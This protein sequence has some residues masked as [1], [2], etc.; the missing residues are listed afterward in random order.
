MGGEKAKPHSTCP[1]EEHDGCCACES[2]EM[3]DDLDNG[4]CCGACTNICGSGAGEETLGEKAK[5]HSTC[6]DEEHDGCCACESDEM[7][8]DWDNGYCCGAC[9][10]ICGSGAGEETLGEKAKPHS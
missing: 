8:D 2:D 3:P 7:P 10:Y 9:T 5:P 6:P 1:D 4:Y